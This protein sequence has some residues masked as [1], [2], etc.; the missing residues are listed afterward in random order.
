ML[1]AVLG[2]GA[3]LGGGVL[4]ISPTG[5]LFGMPLSMLEHSPFNSFLIPGIILF[6]VLGLIPVSLTYALLKKPEI[7]WAE[8]LNFYP[9]MYWAWTYTIYVSFALIIWIQLEMSFIRAV[10]WSHTLYVFFAIAILYVALL[11]KIRQLYATK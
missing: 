1:L 3:I 8:R 6:C 7:K 9:D 11:P 5:K 10:H 4:I 2:T